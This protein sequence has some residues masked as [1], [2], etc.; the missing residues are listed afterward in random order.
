H[1]NA[2]DPAFEISWNNKQAPRFGAADDRYSYG[3]IYR[4]QLIRNYVEA[5]LA[6]RNKM[7]LEQLV[8]AMDEAATQDIRMVELWPLLKR[9]LGTPVNPSLD[10]AVASL[11]AWYAAGGHRRDLTNT[12]ISSP[13]TYQHNQA[14][15]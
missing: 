2:I 9:V 4:M 13:G 1:P 3:A 8:S 12:S 15:T 11:D 5:D 7:G 6:G 10:E 14:I